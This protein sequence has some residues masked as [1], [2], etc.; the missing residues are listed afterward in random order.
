MSVTVLRSLRALVNVPRVRKGAG[1]DVALLRADL[2]GGGMDPFLQVDAFA[3]AEPFFAPHP[4]AGFCAVTYI[5]PESPIGFIN[6]DSLGTRNRIAPGALHWTTAGSGLHHEEI[7][8][9][10]G[11]TVLGMQVFV[12]LPARLK[13]VAPGFLHLD[14]GGVA[15]VERAGATI[16]AVVGASNGIQSTVVPPTPGVRL[17][18]VTLTPGAEFVQDLTAQENAFLWVYAGSA[19]ADTPAG[20]Q[21][22]A[23]FDLAG[24]HPGGTGIRLTAGAGGARLMLFAGPPLGQPIVA[25]GPFVMST[26]REMEQILQDYRAGRLGRLAPSRY[27]PDNRPLSDGA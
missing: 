17:I 10:R 16:R 21:A 14:A 27:G 26:P 5:L 9:V 3:L 25:Q 23:A 12:D 15:T 8:E 19:T 11:I 1:F 20:P 4:H 18:H 13:H 22:L 24:Y 7:P 2:I 6:R